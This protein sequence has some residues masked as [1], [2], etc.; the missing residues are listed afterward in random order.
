MSLIIEALKRARDD[1]VRRQAASKGLPLAPVPRLNGRSRWLTLA[2]IPLAGALVIC[3]LLLFDLY[4]QM[5]PTSPPERASVSTLSETQEVASEASAPPDSAEV[6]GNSQTESIP[7]TT[8]PAV[9][10]SPPLAEPPPAATPANSAVPL[11]DALPDRISD[12]AVREA[13]STPD[14]I[15]SQGAREFVGQAQ[16]KDGQLVD[17][18]GIAWSELEPFALLNGQVVGVGEFVRSYRVIEIRQDQIVLEEGDD[19]ILLRLK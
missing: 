10:S 18:E 13:P 6:S 15:P 5:P 2:L 8:A 1:A 3:V 14:P 12:P 4:S 19:R 9:S 7:Q 16:L 11:P 17:L